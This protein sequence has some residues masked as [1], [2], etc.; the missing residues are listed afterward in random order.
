MYVFARMYIYT[1]ARRSEQSSDS[2]VETPAS[3]PSRASKQAGRQAWVPLFSLYPARIRTASHRLYG[4]LKYNHLQ[5]YVRVCVCVLAGCEKKTRSQQGKWQFFSQ[6]PNV[7]SACVRDTWLW[8]IWDSL[9]LN[10]P[11]SA[12]E[13]WDGFEW[14]LNGLF[15]CFVVGGFALEID[16]WKAAAR[17]PKWDHFYLHLNGMK[18]KLKSLW[19]LWIVCS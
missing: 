9:C 5:E 3:Q 12:E 14:N 6:K 2:S 1:Y 7:R 17:P 4:V 16:C 15:G 18:I 19:C 10:L 11:E 8:R 13:S